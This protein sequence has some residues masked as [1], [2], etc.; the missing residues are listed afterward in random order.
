M[1]LFL[2]L[3]GWFIPVNLPLRSVFLVVSV[4]FFG[5]ALSILAFIVLLQE[6][7]AI[8]ESKFAGLANERFFRLK[9]STESALDGLHAIAGWL[10]TNEKITRI[11]FERFARHLIKP[12]GSAQAFEWIPRV[13]QSQREHFEAAARR[14][15]DPDFQITERQSQGKMVP[16]GTRA[17]YYP[18]HYVYPLQ[19]NKS[20]LG[21]DLGSEPS[22]LA[23]LEK[24]RDTGGIVAFKRITLVQEKRD[25]YGFL[26]F[27]PVYQ[28]RGIPST[29]ALRNEDLRGFVLGVLRIEQIVL[30]S[31]L[32]AVEVYLFD[33]SAPAGEQLLFPNHDTLKNSSDL[34]FSASIS[35]I[36]SLADRKLK[37]VVVPGAGSFGDGRDWLPWAVLLGGI[38]YT[39]SLS[40]YLLAGFMRNI[41]IHN[42]EEKFRN[43][44]EGSI[45]GMWVHRDFKLLFANQALADMF[46]Y[47]SPNEVLSLGTN[48]SLIDREHWEMM[49]DRGISRLKEEEAEAHYAFKG[50]CKDGM[51]I[52]IDIFS[53]R[54]TWEGEPAI[55]STLVNITERKEAEQKTKEAMAQLDETQ[56]QLIATGKLAA[57]GQLA[58]G[59]AHEINNPLAII[60]SSAEMLSRI[61]GDEKIGEFPNVLMRKHLERIYKNVFRSKS[62]VN[63]LLKFSRNDE[64]LLETVDVRDLLRETIRLVQD[65]ALSKQRVFQLKTDDENPVRSQAGG[66]GN[67]MLRTMPSQLQQVFLNL[68]LNAVQATSDH[69]TIS[70]SV[71]SHSKEM[72]FLVS[73]DGVGIPRE[74]IE[75]VFQPLFTTKPIGEGTG[76]GL[77]LCRQIIASLGGQIDVKR[78]LDEGAIFRVVLPTGRETLET[79]LAPSKG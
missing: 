42:S 75:K 5:T 73:D 14:E 34:R 77:A 19:G 54:V 20:A 71:K 24:A 72:E 47:A 44:I 53:Q 22:R 60:A 30:Q 65:T 2:R 64:P 17:E 40:I 18:V 58:A 70:I 39:A 12:N 49:K 62:I 26:V 21:F 6:E 38:L 8:V 52:W 28:S 25:Q 46:G 11:G 23:A 51:A 45:Q 13:F 37:V 76:L 27:F 31:L 15:V 50:T 69:G 9:S 35:K 33:L 32:G 43:L 7:A 57:M 74:N 66:E 78:G 29:Q 63:N 41:R 1:N 61:A 48:Q 16:A 10:E 56:M 3:S 36:I 59:I 67:F 79:L 68:L 4:F 55:Q